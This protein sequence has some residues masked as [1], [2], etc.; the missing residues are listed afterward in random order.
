MPPQLDHIAILVKNT[1]EALKFYQETMGLSYKLSEIIEEVGVRL[2]HLDLGNLDLQLVEPLT[3]DHPLSQQLQER[4]EHLHHLCLKVDD[5]PATMAEWPSR[6][7]EA[8]NATP[9]R[10]PNGRTAAFIAP[11]TTR[12]IQWEVTAD[13][14][15]KSLK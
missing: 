15:T 5:V 12:G 6:G 9:H 13:T 2:T 14:H 7:L 8:K 3:E 10:G 11:E 1:E 4:G